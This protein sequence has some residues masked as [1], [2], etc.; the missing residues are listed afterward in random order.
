MDEVIKHLIL[1]ALIALLAL[2]INEWERSRG[3]YNECSVDAM[4]RC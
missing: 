2:K 3:E 1:F 4:E